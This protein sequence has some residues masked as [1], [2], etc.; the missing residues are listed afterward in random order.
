MASM[1]DNLEQLSI[2]LEAIDS[3]ANE[4]VVDAVKGLIKEWTLAEADSSDFARDYYDSFDV[5]H[6]PSGYFIVRFTPKSREVESE[7]KGKAPFDMRL[8]MLRPG[9][10]GVKISKQGYLYR[11][12]PL[13]KKLMSSSAVATKSQGEQEMQQTIRNAI[14]R[15]N[16]KV[17]SAMQV[18]DRFVVEEA[19]QSNDGLLRVKSYASESDYNKKRIPKM[20]FIAFRSIST[21]PR[22]KAAWLNP[23][24]KGANIQKQA[25]E[26][27]QSN[28]EKIRVEVI[29]ELISTY[30]TGTGV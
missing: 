9:Q 20:S 6:D 26:W 27:L 24:W 13:S 5:F 28:Q 3:Q 8:V 4:V 19:A 29:N 22:S 25:T 18:G 1:I 30:L 23:G 11:N 16:F 2:N 7:E 21:N 15:V 14:A 10:S 12:V 17:K